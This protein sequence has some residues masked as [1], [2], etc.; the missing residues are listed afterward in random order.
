LFLLSAVLDWSS[1]DSDFLKVQ[2]KKQLWK[3]NAN[4]SHCNGIEPPD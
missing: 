4:H 1:S 2:Q 3:K